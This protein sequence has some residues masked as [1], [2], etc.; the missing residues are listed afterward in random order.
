MWGVSL[1]SAGIIVAY[2]LN[3][4]SKHNLPQQEI[5]II[6]RYSG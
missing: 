4:K 6:R 5:P 1:L 2:E 3:R